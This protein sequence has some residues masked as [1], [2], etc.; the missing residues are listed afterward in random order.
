[1][2]LYLPAGR[3]DL[4]FEDCTQYGHIIERVD[5]YEDSYYEITSDEESSSACRQ[6]LPVENSSP[7]A[8]CYMWI[9]GP[10]SVSFGAN[11]LGEDSIPAGAERIFIVPES[12]YDLKAEGC[13]FELLRIELDVEISGETLWAVPAGQ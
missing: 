9:A 10:H 5:I 4:L 2:T 8:I 13:D 12:T 7:E 3:Y 11:W 1:L 6:S